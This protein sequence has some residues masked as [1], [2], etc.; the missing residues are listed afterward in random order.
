VL[1]RGEVWAILDQVTIPVYRVCL[2]TIY[3]CGLRL[4]EGGR[5]QVEQIDSARMQLHI[6]GKGGR[7]R[8]VPLPAATLQMLRD[9]WRTH[10]S[11]IWLF[12]ARTRKGLKHH[13]TAIGKPPRS[14]KTDTGV[15]HDTRPRCPYCGKVYRDPPCDIPR[16]RAPP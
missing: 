10:R 16:S 9:H 11:P 14:P 13:L 1:S 15:V 7:D 2:T 8:L 6:R 3:S 12:P 4:L 5:L